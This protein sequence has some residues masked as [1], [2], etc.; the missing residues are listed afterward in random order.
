MA[1]IVAA[2]VA[3]VRMSRCS[4]SLVR[5]VKFGLSAVQK[6]DEVRSR[7]QEVKSSNTR[8]PSLPSAQ[9]VGTSTSSSRAADFCMRSNFALVM[10]AAMTRRRTNSLRS[11][12]YVMPSFFSSCGPHA[13]PAWALRGRSDRGS[14]ASAKPIKQERK[15]RVFCVGRAYP[16]QNSLL[17]TYATRYA[18]LRTGERS[19]VSACRKK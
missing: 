19:I 8:A 15:L 5:V 16:A 4:C 17:V 10:A 14:L 2:N 6:E 1:K 9:G 11:R 3:D 13:L 12:W 18:L 7:W